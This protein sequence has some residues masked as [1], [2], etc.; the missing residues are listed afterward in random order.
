MANNAAIKTAILQTK[1]NKQTIESQNITAK[2]KQDDVKWIKS[3]IQQEQIKPLEVSKDFV[4]EY[5][6]REKENEERLTAQVERHICTLKN[7]RVKLENRSDLK[8]RSEEY[9]SW[10]ADFLP[11]KNAVM[12]GRTIEQAEQERKTRQQGLSHR[13][14]NGE[15]DDEMV[16]QQLHKHS[17]QPARATLQQGGSSQDLHTVLDSLNRLAELE[18]RITHLEKDNKYDQMLSLE[19]PSA[20]QRTPIEFRK[21]R[22]AIPMNPG[23]GGAVGLK[24]QLKGPQRAHPPLSLAA[25]TRQRAQEVDNNNNEEE[26]EYDDEGDYD[27]DQESEARARGNTFLTEQAPG[28]GGTAANREA[29]RRERARQ[30]ALAS[31]GQKNMRNRVQMR[32]GRIKEQQLGA[33]KHEEAMRELARRKKEQSSRPQQQAAAR[34]SAV[35]PLKG[36]AAGIRSKNKHL[37]DFEALKQGHKKR[38]EEMQKKLY[39]SS[40]NNSN[41]A[42]AKAYE[43][44]FISQTA[45]AYSNKNH[46]YH[47]IS[48]QKEGT[49]TRRT[50]DKNA[51]VRR[52]PNNNGF[53]GQGAGSAPLSAPPMIAVTG[54]GGLRVIQAGRRK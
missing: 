51:P 47:K 42:A 31:E 13:S 32:K 45:P 27:G 9:R 25:R 10:Q 39:G 38:K 6:R 20:N 41:P 5:E 40:N 43:H 53:E 22:V 4:L 8:Q 1:S 28:A 16:Q 23:A 26:G 37:Q 36:L 33:R 52:R 19:K 34:L 46:P 54:M 35:P 12:L 3:V 21:T 49:V 17:Q 24:F 48:T 2:H 18:S 50:H 30:L 44:R 7:L 15:E 29:L 14:S 11:K